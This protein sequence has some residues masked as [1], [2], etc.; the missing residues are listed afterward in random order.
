MTKTA[1][2][3]SGQGSQ[4]AG[5]GKEFCESFGYV[6]EIYECGGDILGYDLKR[7]CFEGEEELKSTLYAQPA[8]FAMGVAGFEAARRELGF[9]PY[10]VAGH[11]LGEYPALYAA[12]AFGLEDGFRIIKARAEALSGASAAGAMAMYAIIGKDAEAV[13]AACEA[14][15]GYVVPANYNAET[16]IVI[17]GLE[18]YAAKA[19]EILATAGAKTVRLSVSGAFH[20]AL[21]EEAAQAFRD[22]VEAIGFK[23]LKRAFFS[24]VT[25]GKLA[26]ENYPEYFY[27]HC[28][29]PV[30]FAEQA[31]SMA[32]DGVETCVDFGPKK[33]AAT[34]L[35]KNVRQFIVYGVE[36]LDTLKKFGGSFV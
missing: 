11:S 13:A 19:A 16:Q 33:T 22:K 5:M 15:G 12:G 26:P 20:T 34:L 17:S 27:R 14:A 2:V 9:E 28:V 7:V 3:F 24:N 35:K 25:C 21:M 32:A 31:R 1:A 18:E 30:L 36:D 8:I 23:P 10:C 29:S 4:Y 6:R